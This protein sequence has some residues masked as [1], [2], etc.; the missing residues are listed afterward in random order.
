MS[1]S[2]I[3]KLPLNFELANGYDYI[4]VTSGIVSDALAISSTLY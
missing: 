3:V 1:G 2:I 4:F